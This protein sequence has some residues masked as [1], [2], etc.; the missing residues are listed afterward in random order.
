M[1]RFDAVMCFFMSNAIKRVFPGE[2]QK[3]LSMWGLF[4]K[5]PKNTQCL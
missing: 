5:I 1:R 2:R 3:F 4:L